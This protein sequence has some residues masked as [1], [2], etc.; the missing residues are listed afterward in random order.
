MFEPLRVV[1]IDDEPGPR[2][3]LI[4]Q[5]EKAGCE[6]A[7]SFEFGEKFLEWLKKTN[8]KI[9]AVFLDIGMPSDGVET[10]KHLPPSIPA[11]F[12]SGHGIDYINSIMSTTT[13]IGCLL[14][15]VTDER[16][17][18]GIKMIRDFMLKSRQ[19]Y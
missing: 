4:F 16:I 19:D 6:I 18:A 10:L 15:P 14:K 5:L 17:S 12:V 2:G 13:A 3:H 9:D 11:V 8:E 7:A 1:V